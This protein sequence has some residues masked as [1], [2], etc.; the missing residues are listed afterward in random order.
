MYSSYFLSKRLVSIHM[1]AIQLLL[2]RSVSSLNLTN[3]Y[4]N[5]KCRVSEGKYQSGSKYEENLNYL[6]KTVSINLQ[7]GF[8]HISYGEAPNTVAFIFQCRGDSY[9]SKCRSCYAT[10]VAGLR[11]RCERNKGGIIWYDQCFLDVSTSDQRAPR[12]IDYENRFSLHNPNNINGET[13]LFNKKTE[14]FLYNLIPKA[15]RSAGEG[16][17]PIYYAAGEERLGTKKLYAMVQCAKDIALCKDCLELIIRELSKC[18]QGK[19]GGRVLS[20]TCN[21]RY[22]LYPF[23]S[24]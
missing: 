20:T 2:I 8:E 1:L 4:L 5:H 7:N 14:D 21:L 22:E 17:E 10:A 19:Q 18:C 13:K 23:I 11:R 3:A 16:N 9:G 12:K 24:T 15:T 6:I